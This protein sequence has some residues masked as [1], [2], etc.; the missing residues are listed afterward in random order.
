MRRVLY[1][2][3]LLLAASSPSWAQP[4]RG[5]A[6]AWVSNATAHPNYQ[7]NSAG[8]A[9][10]VTNPGTGS[11]LVSIPN[12]GTSGGTM[13]VVAYGGNHYCSS[14]GWNPSG[15]TQVVGVL[16]YSAA[17]V[18]VNGAFSVLFY[19]ESRAASQWSDGYLWADQPSN[20]SY[21]PSAS[22]QWNSRGG[23]NTV[24]R[25][26]VGRYIATFPGLG[27]LAHLGNVMVTA[28]FS[29][30]RCRVE[31]WGGSPDVLVGVACDTPAGA[32]VDAFYDLS[33][34]SDTAFGVNQGQEQRRGAFVWTN[35]SASASYT[36]SLFYQYNSSGGPI[37]AQRTG[38]G[39]YR[40][41]IPGLISASS[42]NV[43][44]TR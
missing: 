13:Q 31:S 26:A 33:F 1:A 43:Q 42:S 7:F 34:I 24:V 3:L 38:V 29:N 5:L 28:Y 44:V 21:T 23:S 32:A 16:C 4:A 11:Y 17:G 14:G 39:Q 41:D 30:A 19:K 36:P 37:R 25:T 2:W 20:A 15:T 18:A 10:T 40:V 8:G 9:I 27:P 35:D 22:Y 12:M 6:W